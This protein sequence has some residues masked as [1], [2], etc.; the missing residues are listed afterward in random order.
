MKKQMILIIAISLTAVFALAQKQPLSFSS[1][2]SK[3][4]E[5]SL[6]QESSRLLN[7]A[8]EES[9]KRASHHWLPKVYLNVKSYQSND[10]GASFVGLLDQRSLTQNDFNPDSINH[11]DSHLYTRGALGFDLAL[12]EGGMKVSQVEAFKHSA[13]AQKNT[14]AQIHLEQ[15]SIVGLSYGS[16]AILE[17]QKRK[18]QSLSSE[19]ARMIQR[20]QLGNKSNPVGYSGLLGMKSLANRI[21]GIINQ[22]EAQSRSYYATLSE[23]GLKES[24]W[25]PENIDSETFVNKYF[26]AN[27]NQSNQEDALTSYKIQSSRENAKASEEMA[28]MEKSKYLPRIGAFGETYLFNGN[29]DT[30]NGYNAGLYLQ[31]NLY[32]PSEYGN[33]KEAKLKSMSAAKFSKSSEQQERADRS[34]LTEQLK[35]LRE[36]LNLL[37]GSYALL[38]EQ[39]KMTE[40]LFKN[41]SINA[42]QIVEVM[43]RRT[44]LISQ[45]SDAELALIKAGAQIVTKQKFEIRIGRNSGARNEK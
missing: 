6:A 18:L 26:S 9:Q 23:L 5:G 44:D 42:L 43:S 14:T 34:V 3:I 39:S 2:W 27:S 38:I 10:P 36:N 28:N 16:I 31:W 15:Y 19:I 37:N 35:S 45:Q 22:F 4:D 32:D 11:P 29:R 7:E 12:Y 40:T 8:L 17:E 21:S 30:A 1:V 24:N 33:Y 13:A 41:G 20:Y 25:I